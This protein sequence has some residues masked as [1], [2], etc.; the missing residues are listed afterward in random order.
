[1]DYANEL[2]EDVAAYNSLLTEQDKRDFLDKQRQK[3]AQ[4]TPAQ[5]Q[6]HQAAIAQQVSQIA[7]RI[8]KNHYSATA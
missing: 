8:E 1:M 2:A 4:M 3:I 6:L 7:R 5:R